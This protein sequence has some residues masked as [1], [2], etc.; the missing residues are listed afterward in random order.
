MKYPSQYSPSEITEL[1]VK[2]KDFIQYI[3]DETKKINTAMLLE[4]EEKFWK[5][6]ANENS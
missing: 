2:W 4:N 6:Q 3:N 1:L 5:E